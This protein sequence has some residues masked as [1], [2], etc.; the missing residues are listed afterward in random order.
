MENR[1]IGPGRIRG[2]AANAR[3]M[4]WF[5]GAGLEI[6]MGCRP[7]AHLSAIPKLERM[8]DG[9]GNEISKVGGLPVCGLSSRRKDGR[10]G[11]TLPAKHDY[12]QR[13]HPDPGCGIVRFGGDAGA[14]RGSPRSAVFDGDR[15]YQHGGVGGFC[16]NQQNAAVDRGRCFCDFLYSTSPM[17]GE[18][19]HP[20]KT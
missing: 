14:T 11:T 8:D 15:F 7:A 6:C 16:G 2:D 9:R 20:E 18:A 3:Q 13:S 4:R 5:P 17:A 1:L 19:V 10:V 12:Y